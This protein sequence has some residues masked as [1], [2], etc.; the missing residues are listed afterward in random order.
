ML[1]DNL[2]GYDWVKDF[3]DHDNLTRRL[4]DNVKPSTSE[5][6]HEMIKKFFENLAEA[7]ANVSACSVFNYN[8][9]NIVDDPGVKYCLVR[10]GLHKVEHK[11]A[12]SKQAISLMLCGNATGQY[13]PPMS[14]YKFKNLY[15]E[16]TRNGPENAIYGNSSSGWFD[17]NLFEMWFFDI[18]LDHVK[19]MPGKKCFWVTILAS[20]SAKK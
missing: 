19:D 4:V 9:T 11:I 1:K 2:P 6:N 14:V 7:S 3:K 20:T 17:G 12:H 10:R 13:L 5:I 8:E 18:F 16:W 15:Y